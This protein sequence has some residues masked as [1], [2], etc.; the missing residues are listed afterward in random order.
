MWVVTS[1]K[2]FPIEITL[3]VDQADVEIYC[4]K[5]KSLDVLQKAMEKRQVTD[6]KGERM[7]IFKVLSQFFQTSAP[8][9][10]PDV[11][12]LRAIMLLEA[13]HLDQ[14]F[15]E[16]EKGLILK[17]LNEKY[18]LTL[19]EVSQLQT[20]AEKRRSESHDLFMF[21]RKINDHMNKE[22]KIELLV[23]IWQVVLADGVVTKY[24]DH[25]MSRLKNLL[26]LDQE[27]WVLAQRAAKQRDQNKS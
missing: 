15:A 23:E 24:E 21:T 9:E 11:H 20:L 10:K 8:E 4:G 14:D 13:A 26:R 25:M 27:D 2:G 18:G 12:L 19:E 1:W 3:T 7:Q 5:I 22:E 16:E 6:V 17:I